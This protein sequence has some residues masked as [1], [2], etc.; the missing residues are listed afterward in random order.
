MYAG[1]EQVWGK[2]RMGSRRVERVEQGRL[3]AKTKEMLHCLSITVNTK[4]EK[5]MTVSWQSTNN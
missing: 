1:Q 4:G 5:K 3:K 2:S